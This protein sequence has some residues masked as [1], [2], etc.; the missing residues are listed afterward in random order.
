MEQEDDTYLKYK[1]EAWKTAVEVQQHFNTIE[2]QIRNI[3]VTVLTAAIA[4]AGLTSAN[5]RP[6]TLFNIHV[7]STDS[8]A[9]CP[10]SLDSVLYDGSMVVSS[11]VGRI[12]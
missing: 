8:T 6:V 5:A 2:M 11:P 7:P 1:F 9:C 4:A 3:A 10:N 12:S